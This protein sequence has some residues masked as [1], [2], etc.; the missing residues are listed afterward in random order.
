MNQP[1]PN[2][3]APALCA[4][5]RDLVDQL[6]DHATTPAQAGEAVARA[7]AAMDMETAIRAIEALS[8]V[9]RPH[10]RHLWID[11]QP[12]E[13]PDFELADYQ[14]TPGL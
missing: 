11:R 7:F 10:I 5:W 3:D 6:D 12:P 8:D 14:A 1:D 13:D 2:L 4:A 9:V